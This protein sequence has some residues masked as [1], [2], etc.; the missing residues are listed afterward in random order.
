[1]RAV[2]QLVRVVAVTVVAVTVVA[3]A[4]RQPATGESTEGPR[5]SLSQEASAEARRTI[6][7]WL[8]CEE[9][10]EGELDSV[11]AL[12]RVAVPTLAA[13]LIDGPAPARLEE[14]RQHLLALYRRQVEYAR[15]HPRAAPTM[16]ESQYMAVYAGNLLARY[17]TRS[18]IALE[19]IG[20]PT[21]AEALQRALTL[22]LRDDERAVVAAAAARIRR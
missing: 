10:T 21:A 15:S 9:C 6:I 19:R 13:T 18:A 22:P 8:E 20:G 16:S 12:G 7:Q 11:L 17:R 4:C 2:V 14:Q 5:P 1:M 3:A